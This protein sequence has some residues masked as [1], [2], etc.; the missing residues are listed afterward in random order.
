MRYD[1][2]LITRKKAIKIGRKAAFLCIQ[3]R[4]PHVISAPCAYCL[5]DLAACSLWIS[6]WGSKA[7]TPSRCQ[8]MD[9]LQMLHRHISQRSFHVETPIWKG[10][11]DSIAGICKPF[12][13][14]GSEALRQWSRIT[15]VM[16]KVSPTEWLSLTLRESS[17]ISVEPRCRNRLC[18]IFPLSC[19]RPKHSRFTQTEGEPLYW[20]SRSYYHR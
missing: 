1:S 16:I 5:G 7:P 12:S 18:N 14:P 4:L 17:S 8:C 3:Q 15:H 9:C 6:P 2:E 11:P 13:P 19:A 20:R 10:L